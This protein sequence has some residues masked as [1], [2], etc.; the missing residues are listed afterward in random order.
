[1]EHPEGSQ[2]IA[3]TVADR[4]FVMLAFGV[5]RVWPVRGAADQHAWPEHSD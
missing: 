1:M 5:Q 3:R 2:Q 4:P